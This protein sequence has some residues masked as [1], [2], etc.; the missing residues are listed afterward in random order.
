MLPI[1]FGQA[2]FVKTD[3]KIVS[4]MHFSA[5]VAVVLSLGASVNAA[6]IEDRSISCKCGPTDSCWPS[7]T[8]WN[9]LNQTVGGRLIKTV[10]VGSV[11]HT[12]TVVDQTT[13][14]NY[15]AN[16]C[17]NVQ[18]NWNIPNVR[19]RPSMSRGA[20]TDSLKSGMN[21]PLAQL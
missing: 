12:N 18:A 10:P 19:I 11:C 4:K 6:A 21:S 17:A 1:D 16:Q 8:A 9:K 14:H 3:P 2:L 15:D 7:A 5:I 13:L 20:T